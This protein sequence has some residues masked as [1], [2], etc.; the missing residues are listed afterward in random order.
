LLY[1]HQFLASRPPL[2]EEGPINAEVAPEAPEAC[3]NLDRD[4]AKGSMEETDST[5][6]PPLG[7]I[8]KVETPGRCDLLRYI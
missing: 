6:S 8:E 7:F 5:L 1:D 4:G 3:E 2:P